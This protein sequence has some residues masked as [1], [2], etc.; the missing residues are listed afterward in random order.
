MECGDWIKKDL[1]TK[2]DSSVCVTFIFF[3]VQMTV[4]KYGAQFRGNSQHDALEFLLWLLDRLHEDSTSVVPN[5]NNRS[6]SSGKVRE[7]NT[8]CMKE[9]KWRNTRSQKWA[10]NEIFLTLCC[11]YALNPQII[12]WNTFD[13]RKLFWII[14]SMSY[15]CLL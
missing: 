7:H 3:L 10:Q 14:I 11:H 2:S 5:G 9:M 15:Q 1:F 13:M 8:T 4:S 12:I 6:K